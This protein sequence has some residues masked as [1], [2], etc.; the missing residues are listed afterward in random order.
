MLFHMP[1]TERFCQ[2]TVYYNTNWDKT[3]LFLLSP[4]Y[5]IYKKNTKKFHKTL[6]CWQS[7]TLFVTFPVVWLHKCAC[8]YHLVNCPRD[9]LRDPMIQSFL[10]HFDTRC[11]AVCPTS[12]PRPS[13]HCYVQLDTCCDFRPLK[14]L[15][16]FVT[17]STKK[18]S[19]LWPL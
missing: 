14:R 8:V 9:T 18:S 11:K 10:A 6:Q 19:D 1:V 7:L 15:K 5:K 16:R 13:V 3:K 12:F 4:E 2:K 17:R